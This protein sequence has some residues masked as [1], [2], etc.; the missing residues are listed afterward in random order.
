MGAEYRFATTR[1]DAVAGVPETDDT[2]S[3]RALLGWLVQRLVALGLAA[4][5]LLQPNGASLYFDATVFAE[6]YRFQ[7]PPAQSADGLQGTV[8]RLQVTA[9]RSFIDKLLGRGELTADSALLRIIIEWLQRE[10]DFADV[11]MTLD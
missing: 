6:P 10:A 5:V 7:C 4:E 2:T 9:Q 11:T 3:Q 8:W 1:F